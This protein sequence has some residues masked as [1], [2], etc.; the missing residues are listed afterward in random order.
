MVQPY[1]PV[2]NKSKIYLSKREKRGKG[3]LTTDCSDYTDLRGDGSF[4]PEGLHDRSQAR[5]AWNHAEI[6]YPLFAA[7]RLGRVSKASRLTLFS[8]RLA[9][10]A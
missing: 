5:S 9:S 8:Q 3:D 7:S 1:D 10:G 4:V 2:N 6:S